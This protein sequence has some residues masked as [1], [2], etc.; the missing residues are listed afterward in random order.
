M[1]K[2]GSM[3]FVNYGELQNWLV[4]NEVINVRIYDAITVGP[5]KAIFV[6]FEYEIKDGKHV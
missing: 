5:K 1:R 3:F 4:S 2:S 6:T